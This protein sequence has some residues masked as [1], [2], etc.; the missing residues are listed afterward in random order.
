MLK[1]KVFKY[2]PYKKIVTELSPDGSS[3]KEKEILV[4]DAYIVVK[5]DGDSIVGDA[6]RL[7]SLGI[8]IPPEISEY[9]SEST[10]SK[11]VKNVEKTEPKDD[12]PEEFSEEDLIKV[13]K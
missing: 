9:K 13:T 11:I 6:K 4:K 2:K 8:M 5:E 3:R 1:Y 10:E 12:E 7:Q